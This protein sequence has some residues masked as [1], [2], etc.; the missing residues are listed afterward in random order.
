[1]LKAKF[2]WKEMKYTI[3]QGTKDLWNGAK[4]IVNLYKTKKAG[5]FTGFEISQSRRIK[6]DLLKFI[7]Y[8]VILTV[9]LA[10]L[11]LPFILW[12]FPNAV[13]SYYLFDTAEDRLYEGY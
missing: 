7:P 2:I 8:S 9:P 11:S 10:E 1:M 5:D 4:W 3:V 12:L 6:V 13:P